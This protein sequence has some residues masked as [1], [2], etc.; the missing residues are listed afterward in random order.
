M[1]GARDERKGKRVGQEE[2]RGEGGRERKGGSG[3]GSFKKLSG[4]L[5]DQHTQESKSNIIR[6]GGRDYDSESGFYFLRFC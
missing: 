2:R 3:G 1:A 5:V 4:L 6:R